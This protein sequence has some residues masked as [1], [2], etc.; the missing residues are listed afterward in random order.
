MSATTPRAAL[1]RLRDSAGSGELA[2]FCLERGVRLLVAF[3][4][5][6]DPQRTGQ[7]HDLDL[8]VSWSPGARGDLFGLIADLVGWL[9]LDEIDVVDLDRAGIVVR[10]Q[11]LAHGTPLVEAEP[12]LFA[13]LQMAAI[14]Q[15]MD[16]E[17]LRR[18]DLTLLAG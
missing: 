6:T 3:G 14:T 11:A 8:A 4:S 2:R 17:W 16:T 9:Q 1:A 18:L 15:R 7:A 5:A 12:G 13:R 10:E